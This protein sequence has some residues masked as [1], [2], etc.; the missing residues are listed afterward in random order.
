MHSFE[1]WRPCVDCTVNAP[2]SSLDSITT[3]VSKMEIQWCRNVCADGYTNPDV[4]G[5]HGSMLGA[6]LSPRHT[7]TAHVLG[8]T[9]LEGV[10]RRN[11]KIINFEYA[12]YLGLGLE[13]NSKCRR[14]FLLL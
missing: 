2:Q 7:T 6:L 11:L 5:A 12:L 3:E 10:N 9:R 4:L 8:T 1:I 14:L 13:M